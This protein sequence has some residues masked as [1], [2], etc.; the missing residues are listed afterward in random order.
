MH[1]RVIW[2]TTIRYG[3]ERFDISEHRGE[4]S[5]HMDIRGPIFPK[6]SARELSNK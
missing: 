1:G 3:I 4:D 2:F 5:A 6:I